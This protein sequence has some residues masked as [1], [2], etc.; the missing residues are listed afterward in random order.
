MYIFSD[1]SNLK[2]PQRHMA[3]YMFYQMFSH[4]H[5]IPYHEHLRKQVRYYNN[6]HLTNKGTGSEQLMDLCKATQ[7]IL[8]QWVLW[9]Y[10]IVLQWACFSTVYKDGTE[11]VWHQHG[12]LDLEI[13]RYFSLLLDKNKATIYPRTCWQSLWAA[14][15]TN[16]ETCPF[17]ELSV[18]W[19]NFQLGLE[20]QLL[21]A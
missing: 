4:C 1:D 18:M 15:P 2:R 14:E 10:P 19:G 16:L 3:L 8:T 12:F 7:L 21:A 20:F 9:I 17:S 5:I 11:N 6:C 13:I